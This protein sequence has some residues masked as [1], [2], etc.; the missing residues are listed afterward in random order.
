MDKNVGFEF[1]NI[2][3]PLLIFFNDND[4]KEYP[5]K[6]DIIN[7]NWL[8]HGMC[9]YDDVTKSDCVKLFLLYYQLIIF[10]ERYYH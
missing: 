1:L 6:P 8:M 7:R 9:N 2:A 3:Y 5:N 10:L 4:W